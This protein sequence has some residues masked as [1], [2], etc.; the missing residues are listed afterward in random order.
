MKQILLCFLVLF[1]LLASAQT[2]TEYFETESHNSLSFTDNG[3]IFNIIS[4]VGTFDIQGNF[5]NT[6]WS[7]TVND[8]RYIDNSNDSATPPSFSIKTTSNLF[9][10]NKFWMYLSALNL[11]LNVAGTLTVIGKLSGVAKFTAT[12]SS[13]FATTLGSTNGYSLIDMTNLNGQNYSNIIIDEL[14]IT[15]GG[16]FR[17]AGL[18]A[19]T[20]VK[21]SGLIS[22]LSAST[23]QFNVS[24]N[25]GSNGIASVSPSG[26]TSP[27]TYVWT[28]YGSQISGS[29]PTKTNLTMG[30]YTCTITDAA[31][32]SIT[33]TFNIT[34]PSIISFT[35]TQSNV[36]TTGGNNGSAGVTVSGGAGSYTYSWAPSGGTL[37]NATNLS[38]GT[39]TVTIRDNN[40]CPVT[41]SFT[42]TEQ[43][44]PKIA[45]ISQLNAPIGATLTLTGTGFN[46]TAANNVVF[47]GAT[48][49]IPTAAT[50]TSI[51]VTVPLGATYGPISVLNTTNGLS[52]SSIL[53]FNPTFSPNKGGIAFADLD[54]KKDFATGYNPF[55]LAIG[56]LDGDGKPDLAIANSS[57]NTVSVLRNTSSNGLITAGS[58]AN[59]VDFATGAYP[60]SVAIADLD[61]DGKPDLA[62]TNT[63]D[64]SISVLRNTSSSGAIN[65]GSFATKVDFATGSTPHGLAIGDLDGDG[66]PDFAIA[67][68]G[69]NSISVLRN[70]S[71]SGLITSSSFAA[72]VDFA[73]GVYPT[74]VAIGDLDGDGKPDLAITNNNSNSV[75]VLHNTSVNGYISTGSFATKVDFTTN[76]MPYRIAIGDL[77][78]DGK[79]DLA[80]ANS[81]TNSISVLRNTS[82]SGLITSSS[83]A[84]RVDFTTG[85]I[86]SS[87]AIG[88]L[89]GDG[90]PDLA[91]ANAS[92]NTV[93]VLRNTSASGSITVASFA[94]KVDFAT[95]TYFPSSVAIGDLDG[96]GKPDLAIT[97]N[98]SNSVSVWRNNPQF[99][100]LPV[101]FGKFTATLQNNRVK[102]DWNTLSESNNQ[103]FMVYR[104]TNGTTYTE[105]AQQASKGNS[106]NSYIAYDNNPTN[107]LNYYRLKQKDIDGT[108][109]ELGDAVVN[110]SLGGDAVIAWPNPTD[111]LLNVS[112]S[113]G[114]YR[115]LQLT[116]ITG[117][118]LQERLLTNTQSE[119]ELEM[120][121]Y[122]K[123]V[124]IIELKGSN[125]S[126][127]VKVLK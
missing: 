36:T 29:S 8:N 6:G 72:R 49:A 108:I 113:A 91:M 124:Y 123:G 95:G 1:S 110:F 98:N 38:A 34:E 68:S 55:S 83:F 14:L 46:T 18:D 44:V 126:H 76:S 88:D 52:G 3:V 33:K 62:I 25:G 63:N 12:K 48:A 66:K 93:S 23:S 20:W 19:F 64:N 116:D 87:L 117:K 79:P 35:K 118:K 78:G 41:T 24:C 15:L 86:V 30:S 101:T 106:A 2:S 112:F 96:D 9:K 16:S 54:P 37:A 80:I 67:N 39:Y 115:S 111:K 53:Y 90:K 109:S 57:S 103:S 32:T 105:I 114:K 85:S 58:F 77:D 121:N 97:N 92:S 17:Y 127:L 7:G 122:P 26:G 102:L 56:D 100:A 73:T 75:S 125:G 70:I 119:I 13:G 69:T 45:N 10:V 51:T 99:T 50:T 81:G 47:F 94:N 59:K 22:A 42:I 104:S 40:S 120:G 31:N 74:S 65:T 82:S 5:P 28:M 27:Y 84:A 43:I 4:H 107:G 11:D 60:R 71:S 61:G 89:D 21:D